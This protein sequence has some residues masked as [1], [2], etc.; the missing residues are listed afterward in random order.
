MFSFKSFVKKESNQK[1]NS[2]QIPNTNQKKTQLVQ[3]SPPH[4]TK[5]VPKVKEKDQV[6]GIYA[7]SYKLL[8]SK[9]KFLYPRLVALESKIDKAMMPAP[10][11]AYVST[12]VLVGIIV[13]VVSM[14]MA[15]VFV[16]IMNIQQLEL[17]IFFPLIAAAAGFEAGLGVM[18]KYPELNISTRKRRL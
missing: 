1:N 10:Y 16:F 12:M 14:V 5:K 15:S 11:E 7:A 18:Y 8:G 4:R 13:G 6:P 9:I 3:P 2:E 17:R